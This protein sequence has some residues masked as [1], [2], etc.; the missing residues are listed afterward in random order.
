[1]NQQRNAHIT[2]TLG[3]ALRDKIGEQRFNTW[4]TSTGARI[5][6]RD[7]AI[8]VKVDEVYVHFLRNAFKS[9]IVAIAQD[10]LGDS[11]PVVFENADRS[12]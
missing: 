1:M 9:D 7:D 4:F 5:E 8:V 12:S 11:R 2:A 3:Q 6:A 10:V